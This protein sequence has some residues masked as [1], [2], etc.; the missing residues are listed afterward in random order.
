LSHWHARLQSIRDDRLKLFTAGLFH[1]AAW[2][3]DFTLDEQIKHRLET[4]FV[5]VAA[6]C[7]DQQATEKLAAYLESDLLTVVPGLDTLT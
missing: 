2:Y 6:M 1:R 3:Y 4:E 7:A 5:C